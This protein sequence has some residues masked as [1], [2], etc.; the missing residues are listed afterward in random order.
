MFPHGGCSVVLDYLLYNITTTQ[1]CYRGT[2]C[3]RYEGTVLVN[4]PSR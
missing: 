2:Y 4:H 3:A 1:N